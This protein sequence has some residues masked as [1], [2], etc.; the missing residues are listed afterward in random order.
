VLYP[1]KSLKFCKYVADSLTVSRQT[2]SVFLRRVTAGEKQLYLK[3]M[4]LK[5]TLLL[6][7]SCVI[8]VTSCKKGGSDNNSNPAHGTWKQTS[9]M[10]NYTAPVVNTVDMYS[11]LSPCFQDD[12]F[13]FRANG[14]FEYNEGT[15]KC[16]P[17][18]PQVKESGTFT[19][20]GNTMTFSNGYTAEIVEAPGPTLKLKHTSTGPGNQYYDIIIYARQ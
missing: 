20:S 19:I 2:I 6:T 11:S 8:I 16:D 18:F 12:L 9:F 1:A 5:N 15:T 4:S 13:V 14:T 3:I 10:R 7:V 17:A